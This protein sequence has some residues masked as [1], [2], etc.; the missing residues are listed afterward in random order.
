MD[1]AYPDKVISGLYTDHKK[2]GELV[3]ELYRKLG[4]PDGKSFLQAYG[5]IVNRAA[6]KKPGGDSKT[7]VL[8]ELKKRYP[9]GSG[10]HK[11]QELK[12]ANPD[13]ASRFANLANRANE[14][15]GMPLARYLVQE[16]ILAEKTNDKYEESGSNKS[17]TVESS[18][19]EIE[20]TAGPL[21]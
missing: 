2:W 3:T 4:Y 8:E 11:I 18:S 21:R 20:K 7:I 12:D 17:R 9:N 16:G 14:F 6:T 15:F 13:L 10:F 1:F 19:N 5:Y